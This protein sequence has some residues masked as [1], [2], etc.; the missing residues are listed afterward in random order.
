LEYSPAEQL[1]AA[2]KI[3][4]GAQRLV[5]QFSPKVELVF[6]LHVR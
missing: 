6:F 4:I 5:F 3:N 1:V 2:V